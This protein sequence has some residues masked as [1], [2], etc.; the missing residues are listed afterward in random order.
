QGQPLV[1]GTA[2]IPSFDRE[3]LI[4]ALRIDHAGENT[5]PE[6]LTAFWRSGGVRYD[7]DFMGRTV[8]YYGCN[9][10]EYV[11]AYPAVELKY[12]VLPRREYGEQF[13]IAGF[14]RSTQVFA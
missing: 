1:S 10:E 6:F 2:D 7:V 11:E 9:G 12:R 4:R 5:F 8:T 13:C 3:E 14:P